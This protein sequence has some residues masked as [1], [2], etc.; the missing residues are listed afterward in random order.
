MKVNRGFI[1]LLQ[2]SLLFVILF[3]SCSNRT[4]KNAFYHP[5]DFDPVKSTCFI[6]S[7]EYY[8][9]IPKLIGIIST[10]DKVT[11]YW[12]ENG[13]DTAT[14]NQIL[15]KYQSNFKNIK[16]V[17]FQSKTNSNWIRDFGPVYLINGYGKRKLVDFGYFGKRLEFNKEIAAKMNIPVIESTFNSSGGARE[18]NGKGTIILCEAHE[19]DVNK[20][21]TKPEIEKEISEKLGIKNFIWMKRGLPQDDSR[22]KGP[23]YEQIYPNG[24]NGHVDQFCRFA[25]ARTILISSVSEEEANQHPILAEAKKRLDENYQILINSND[26]D[27]KKFKIIKVPFAPLLF[28]ERIIA[29]NRMVVTPVTSYMNFIVTNSSVILPSYLSAQKEDPEL[30]NKERVVEQIFRTAFPDREI[31]QAEAS[32][33][34]YFSGGFH[35]ISINEPQPEN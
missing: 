34:N 24:V 27:G 3:T 22:L 15:E 9:I 6:W 35:C 29:N 14:I 32:I 26:Q 25:D 2:V 11:V 31:I 30:E 5:A 13:A 17:Q 19:L 23:L 7:D 8:E 18:T 12:N 28:I 10:K 16:L 21:K 4:D 33:L 1:K 20:P